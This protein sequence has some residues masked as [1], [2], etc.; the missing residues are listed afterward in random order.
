MRI[1]ENNQKEYEIRC[2]SCK[3]KLAYTKSD[4]HYY[5]DDYFGDVHW[6]TY[7]RCPI[8]NSKIILEIY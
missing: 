5:E 8:C 7:L 6:Y 3:S 1:V 2:N 4:I